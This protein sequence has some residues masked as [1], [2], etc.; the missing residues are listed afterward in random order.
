MQDEKPTIDRAINSVGNDTPLRF[1]C[2]KSEDVPP[3]QARAEAAFP[4]VQASFHT[5]LEEALEAPGSDLIILP[6][7]TPTQSLA[8]RLAGQQ[9]YESALQDW[10][11]ETEAFLQI[12]RKVRRRVRIMAKSPLLSGST[13]SWQALAAQ[14][15]LQISPAAAGQAETAPCPLSHL[16]G[17][18][19]I[20]ITP[21]A[22]ALAKEIEAMINGPHP[23]FENNP[24]LVTAVLKKQH[25]AKTE[26][27]KQR[28]L[29]TENDLLK[30]NLSALLRDIETQTI[31]QNTLASEVK[32]MGQLEAKLSQSARE[33]LTAQEKVAT[34]QRRVAELSDQLNAVYASNS[35]KITGPVRKISLLLRRAR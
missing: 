24:E 4:K 5:S 25:D 19:L 6:I 26:E 7:E 31:R 13:E 1:F 30:E 18:Y 17:Q 9:E 33:R 32:L 3:L 16:L 28:H 11:E 12:C 2:L 8:R 14:V 27:A 22:Q 29:S 23:S 15:G 10:F 34:L 35:W 20:Q 21:R